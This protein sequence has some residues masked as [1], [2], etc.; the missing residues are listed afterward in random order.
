MLVALPPSQ[1]HHQH[2]Q[3]CIFHFAIGA[4]TSYPYWHHRLHAGRPKLQYGCWGQQL[5]Y[6]CCQAT[7]SIVTALAST[8]LGIRGASILPFAAGAINS[9]GSSTG[10][11]LTACQAKPLAPSPL[12]S[13]SIIATGPLAIATG[14]LHHCRQANTSISAIKG[15]SNTVCGAN[16]LCCC[17]CWC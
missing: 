12:L 5:R 8:S 13:P 17:G 14:P 6:H 16:I 3:Q 11:I 4:E 9:N 7:T 10:T 2:R 15:T 1:Y